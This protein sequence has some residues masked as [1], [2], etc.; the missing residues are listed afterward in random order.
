MDRK[1]LILIAAA[2]AIVGAAVVILLVF[3]LGGKAEKEPKTPVPTEYTVE[4][5][6]VTAVPEQKGMTVTPLEESEGVTGYRYENLADVSTV[7]EEYIAVLT[8]EGMCCVDAELTRLD[9]PPVLQEE[10]GEIY[11][12][13]ELEQSADG[14][15][16]LSVHMTWG[17]DTC[18]VELQVLPQAIRTLTNMTFMESVDYLYSLSPKQ[19]G[20]PGDSMED[21]RIYVMDGAVI[22]DNRACMQLNV[23]ELD[24]ELSTN[25]FVGSYLVT[26]D[27]RYLYELVDG[28]A[29]Q[30]N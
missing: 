18:T 15:Q 19:L 29:V 16:S 4:D 30:I 24:P 27:S 14:D 21:Y 20:L 2:G 26:A 5:T 22:V 28:Q 12:A 11:L 6:T 25:I 10:E 13:K 1:K 23:Y 17:T 7:L 9:E 8:E 3:L